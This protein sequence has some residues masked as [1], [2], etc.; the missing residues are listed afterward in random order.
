M[1][2]GYGNNFNTMNKSKKNN[3]K[4]FLPRLM[5]WAF[6]A[7]AAAQVISVV[8]GVYSPEVASAG[9]IFD[10]QVP[11]PG[12][13]I[14]FDE[15]TRPIAMYIKAVYTY[16]VGAVGILAAVMLMVGGL[17]WIL[18]GGNSSS[19]SEAKDIIFA[20][21]SGLVLVMT[22]YLILN[23]INPNLVDLEKNVSIT[24]IDVGS[25][26]ENT[27]SFSD[28]NL[29]GCKWVEGTTNTPSFGC[30]ASDNS[31]CNGEPDEK[32]KQAGCCCEYNAIREDCS[33]SN[34]QCSSDYEQISSGWT[35]SNIKTC[36]SKTS[37]GQ[38][39]YDSGSYCC[40]KKLDWSEWEFDPG[41]SDQLGQADPELRTLLGCMRKQLSRAQGKISSIS[42]SAVVHPATMDRCITTY[43]NPPCAHQKKS[44][45]YGCGEDSSFSCAVDFGDEENK[46]AIQKAANFCGAGFVLDE[47]NHIHIS[48][49]SC[50]HN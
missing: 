43:S 30:V 46:A 21:I 1:I 40:C 50:K 6:V 32:I 9:E 2:F 28:R 34:S 25:R 49:E 44:C 29:I 19:I 24:S 3:K 38:S 10:A 33:W 17:R 18:A 31:K 47:G 15:T 4:S 20:S 36:G 8:G 11:I 26:M 42:D 39:L 35:E 27:S 41:I 48:T 23:Q 7:I 22:S 37:D 16:A 13:V 5:A 12:A 45:H 14:E